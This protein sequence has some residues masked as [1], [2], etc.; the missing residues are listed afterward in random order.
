MTKQADDFFELCAD[1]CRIGAQPGGSHILDALFPG[2]ISAVRSAEQAQKRPQPDCPC[3]RMP[4]P[5]SDP[6]KPLELHDN[7]GGNYP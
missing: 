6:C 7:G 1:I 5:S 3:C 4:H 2:T